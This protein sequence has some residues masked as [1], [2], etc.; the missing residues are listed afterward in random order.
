MVQVSGGQRYVWGVNSAD[1]IFKRPIWS[2]GYGDSWQQVPGGLRQV[3]ASASDLV[4]G[5]NGSGEIYRCAKP[6]EGGLAWERVLGNL[7][8]ISAND[9]EVWGVNSADD[10][11]HLPSQPCPE[12]K[13]RSNGL[14]YDSCQQDWAGGTYGDG[15]VCWQHCPGFTEGQS[16]GQV[17]PYNCGIGCAR[18]INACASVL[19]DQINAPINL[20][21]NIISFG[22]AGAATGGASS[23]A[24]GGAAAASSGVTNAALSSTQQWSALL[25]AL[26]QAQSIAETAANIQDVFDQVEA[27]ETELDRWIQDAGE[28]FSDFT[29]PRIERIIDE[30]FPNPDDRVY[31]KRKYALFHFNS[32][33]EQ[34]GW[35]LGKLISGY[36]SYEPTGIVAV[37]DAF[38]QPICKTEATPFPSVTIL[39][40]NQRTPDRSIP[41]DDGLLTIAAPEPPASI[42]P[43]AAGF[44]R[45]QS[46]WHPTRYVHNEND[47]LSVGDIGETWWSAQWKIVP[48]PGGWVQI[49]NRWRPDQYLHN[50][51]GTL[52]VGPIAN[53]WWSAQWKLAPEADGWVR[54]QNR[55]RPEHYIHNQNGSLEVGPIE[56]AWAS[57][58]WK[59][60]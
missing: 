55:W 22:T 1:Q 13:K 27:L 45:I 9:R 17:V 41:A 20:V 35:R 46:R 12:G 51:N 25:N 50:Q 10:V 16:I 43:P 58:L 37:I 5:V 3:S 36:A 18:D 19:L 2:I 33:L 4:W 39:A 60:E 15:P 6:C 38:L 34:D 53:G 59:V 28:S 7:S 26:E 44:A 49:Q 47:A 11:F 48:V 8:Q 56:R 24:T 31:I 54:I 21:L 57:T 23:A 52:E 40:Q 14:C 29:S 32:L 30:Q 42:A